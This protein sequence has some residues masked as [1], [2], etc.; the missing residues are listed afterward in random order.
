[1]IQSNLNYFATIHCRDCLSV[2]HYSVYYSGL[3]NIVNFLHRSRMEFFR[4][5]FIWGIG[6]AAI[7]LFTFYRL[8]DA[9]SAVDDF[10]QLSTDYRPNFARM[11]VYRT[12]VCVLL[13]IGSVRV[14]IFKRR[15][16]ILYIHRLLNFH[17]R[18]A[19]C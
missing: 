1:M 10:F 19:H 5:G 2:S 3:R 6:E 18:T 11:L 9:K 4:I 14:S 16:Q 12:F 17:C 15:G 8:L 13:A 7:N